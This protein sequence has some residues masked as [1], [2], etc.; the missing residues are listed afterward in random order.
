MRAVM[1]VLPPAG[2]GTISLIG[3]VGQLSAAD[4]GNA[5]SANSTTTPI[6]A[7]ERFN[8]ISS[9]SELTLTGST[10]LAIAACLQ[11]FYAPTQGEGFFGY[12]D[13]ACWQPTETS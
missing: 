12:T 5:A 2:K 13:A 4:A 7:V 3:L 9:R 1:S 6:A 11:R 10:V 8:M